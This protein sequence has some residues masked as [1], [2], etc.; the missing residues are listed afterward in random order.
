MTAQTQWQ[1][2]QFIVS[3]W[4][5][6][7]IQSFKD[8]HFVRQ[9]R[10]MYLMILRIKL[11]DREIINPHQLHASFYQPLRRSEVEIIKVRSKLRFIFDLVLPATAP[12]RGRDN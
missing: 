8:D 3:G 5:L 10:A 11:L 2:D 6:R 12:Q 9:Q 4:N 7:E 1:T